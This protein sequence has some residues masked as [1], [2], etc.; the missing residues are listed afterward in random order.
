MVTRWKD[1]TERVCV[2]VLL[3]MCLGEELTGEKKRQMCVCVNVTF[4][5][6]R[7]V[8]VCVPECAWDMKVWSRNSRDIVRL[9]MWKR[10]DLVCAW[11]CVCLR[12]AC[13]F[14]LSFNEKWIM[15]VCMWGIFL[16]SV[17]SKT[18]E[19][20]RED[21]FKCFKNV[22]NTCHSLRTVCVLDISVQHKS[23]PFQ[24]IPS[25]SQDTNVFIHIHPKS[26]S[27]SA[28]SRPS[29]Q[30]VQSKASGGP[31]YTPLSL[32]VAFSVHKR[33]WW[34]GNNTRSGYL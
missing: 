2:Y 5:L 15:C 3:S 26:L 13:T 20:E 10:E 12:V 32:S 28:I 29:L 34:C 18:V 21:L 30:T 22:F 14:K 33:D 4:Q 31:D 7:F 6:N 9:R 23:A 11:W 19:H 17:L 27:C 16:S 8:Y 25:S 24:T 1:S